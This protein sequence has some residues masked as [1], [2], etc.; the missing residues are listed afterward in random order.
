[1][2]NFSNCNPDYLKSTCS[3]K[4]AQLHVDVEHSPRCDDSCHSLLLPH[5]QVW[6]LW[7]SSQKQLKLLCWKRFVSDLLYCLNLNLA[8]LSPSD[9]GWQ[10]RNGTVYGLDYLYYRLVHD[11]PV[12]IDCGESCCTSMMMMTTNTMTTTM[13]LSSLGEMT[14]KSSCGRSGGAVSPL[15]LTLLTSRL[16]FW[17]LTLTLTLLENA[18]LL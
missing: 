6:V 4:A 2:I 5:R 18:K 13:I 16:L 8:I 17:H 3:I 1:M 12:Y 9:K 10:A 7:L 15:V 14:P 11:A